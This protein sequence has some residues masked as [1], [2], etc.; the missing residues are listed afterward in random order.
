MPC[1]D[2]T[3]RRYVRHRRRWW[4]I[5]AVRNNLF[6]CRRAELRQGRGGCMSPNP[7]CATNVVIVDD[8]A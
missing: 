6:V 4:V 8:R 5:L 1:D 2:Y 3:A 7:A